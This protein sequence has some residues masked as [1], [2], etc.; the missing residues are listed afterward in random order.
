MFK[1]SFHVDRA[2]SVFFVHEHLSR[3]ICREW[4]Y[5]NQSPF[6][7]QN[8]AVL[9]IDA[10]ASPGRPF[11]LVR[12][13]RLELPRLTAPEPKSGVSTNFTIPAFRKT[14]A[15]ARIGTEKSWATTPVTSLHR[16]QGVPERGVSI[17]PVSK[18][19]K[20]KWGSTE[21]C[22]FCR[23]PVTRPARIASHNQ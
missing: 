2:L 15:P 10:K 21:K 5:A 14:A 17:S 7:K 4:L 23:V 9:S 22:G 18:G 1:P 8:G 12:V 19:S 11:I 20:E 6:C 16:V 3:S 13:E